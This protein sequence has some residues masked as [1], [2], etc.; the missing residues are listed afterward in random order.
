MFV[1]LKEL[2]NPYLSHP[3]MP[4]AQP[5]SPILRVVWVSFLDVRH[6]TFSFAFVLLFDKVIPIN[7]SGFRSQCFKTW[8]RLVWY[9]A[10][11]R[12]NLLHPSSTFKNV[13]LAIYTG[14]YQHI[15]VTFALTIISISRDLCSHHYQHITWP[16]LS[17]LSAHHVTFPLTTISTSRDLSSHHYQHITVTFALTTISTSPWPLLSLLSADHLDLCSHHYQYITVTFA[18]TTI[19]TSPWPLL[20][21]LSAHHR[22]LCCHHYQHHCDL[23]SHHYQHFTVTFALTTVSTSEFIWAK[24][25]P[26]T[27]VVS[28][29]VHFLTGSN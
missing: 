2:L 15:T 5:A 7:M 21:P 3:L 11:F 19:S 9:I 10:A 14:H 27:A 17:P 28:L 29:S 23:C 24:N 22:D 12:R 1:S 20:S 4:S 25:I 18:L 6:K 16:F 26:E 8:R 13:F